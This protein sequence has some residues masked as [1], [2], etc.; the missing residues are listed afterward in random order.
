MRVLRDRPDSCRAAQACS[1]VAVVLLV[2]GCGTGRAPEGEAPAQAEMSAVTSTAVDDADGT[3]T[4]AGDDGATTTFGEAMGLEQLPQWLPLPEELAGTGEGFQ[5]ITASGRITGSLRIHMRAPADEA[6]LAWSAV[7][8]AAGFQVQ[9]Q[10]SEGTEPLGFVV[11]SDRSHRVHI[12]V[13]AAGD[14][15]DCDLQYSGD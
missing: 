12:S 15:S 7:L 10:L 9:Q 13:S 5:V 11:A 8:T 4:L 14:G 3:M 2:A 6:L 1:L